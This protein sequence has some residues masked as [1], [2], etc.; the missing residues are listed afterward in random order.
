[1]H[2]R[3]DRVELYRFELWLQN[4]PGRCPK[5]WTCPA[6]STSGFVG[7]FGAGIFE[8]V[9][10]NPLR[11][12]WHHSDADSGFHLC[13]VLVR[14]LAQRGEPFPWR[15]GTYE[16]CSAGV[17][18]TTTTFTA[19][20]KRNPQRLCRIN[21]ECKLAPRQECQDGCRQYGVQHRV[22]PC[23]HRHVVE[24]QNGVTNTK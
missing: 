12:V 21:D 22:V 9:E 15:P 10:R 17:L 1:M 5:T 8:S 13:E 3:H 18:L 11:S 20:P 2:S 14:A 16:E 7:A 23:V 4:D 24:K 19:L 6:C